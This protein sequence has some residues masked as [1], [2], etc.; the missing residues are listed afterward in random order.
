M[1]LFVGKQWRNRYRE[2]TYG[3]EQGEERVRCMERVT[4]INPETAILSEV[5]Q[6]QKEKYQI[7]LPISGIFILKM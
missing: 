5:S 2:K 6:T 4:W 3:K 1:N 7:I